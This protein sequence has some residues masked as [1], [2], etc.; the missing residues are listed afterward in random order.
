MAIGLSRSS[1]ENE[2]RGQLGS[3][4]T[5]SSIARAIAEAIDKNNRRITTQLRNAGVNI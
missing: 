5:P 4:P 2:I 1:I 3:N